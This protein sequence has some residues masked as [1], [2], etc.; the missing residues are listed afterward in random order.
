MVLNKVLMITLFH[1]WKVSAV[2][3]VKMELNIS[4]CIHVLCT[5]GWGETCLFCWSDDDSRE[6][7]ADN[8]AAVRYEEHETLLPAWKFDA[9]ETFSWMGGKLPCPTAR[10]HVKN[11]LC[12]SSNAICIVLYQVKIVVTVVFHFYK[13]EGFKSNGTVSPW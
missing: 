3:I 2:I 13:V 12:L 1:I 11:H 9:S 10:L 4:F 8:K 6:K 7:E 5:L